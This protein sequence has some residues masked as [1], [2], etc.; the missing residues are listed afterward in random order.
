VKLTWFSNAPWVP[1]GYGSQTAQVVSRLQD[2]GHEVAV[3]ANYGLLG[4]AMTW[5]PRDLPIF[6]MG[7]DSYSQ[8]IVAAHHANW[9]KGIQNGWIVTLWD[10]WPFRD[11]GFHGA[12]VASWTPVDHWPVPPEIVGWAKDHFTI[13]MSQFGRDSFEREG[14]RA[15]YIPHAIERDVFRPT[16]TF[17]NGVSPRAH[18]GVPEDAFL[19]MVN[20]RNQGINPSRKAFGE[21]FSALSVFMASHLD[22]HVYVHADKIGQSG[23]DLVNLA[24]AVLIP[25]ERMH[26][27]DM[28]AFRVAAI[29]PVDLAALY[30]ASDVL[31]ATSMGEGFGIPVIESQ[32]CGTPAIVT[33]FSAQPELIGGGWK[34][35]WQPYWDATMSAFFATPI[36]GDIITKLEESYEAK[37]DAGIRAACL[38]KAAE[39]D[40]DAIFESHWKPVL[41]EMEALLTPNRETRRKVRSRE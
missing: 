27:V 13:A 18:L 10:V 36:I 29:P 25:P 41:G 38:A 32:A 11:A 37:G 31:L 7:S 20:A 35:A 40:A 15:R 12:H 6:P 33:D 39:Y 17:R 23:V 30:T 26:Y 9:A 14:I 1:S 16:P 24:N 3:A 5:G 8:D 22:V 21:M 28:Y 34:V 19:V 2:A 4:T